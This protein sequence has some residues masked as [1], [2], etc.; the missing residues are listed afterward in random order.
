[1]YQVL[2]QSFMAS[3]CNGKLLIVE[4]EMRRDGCETWGCPI[5]NLLPYT[6]SKFNI[7]RNIYRY[8]SLIFQN[9]QPQM[10]HYVSTSK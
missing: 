6:V 5:N 4:T 3:V 7:N 10:H 8:H 1:M 9:T 2:V